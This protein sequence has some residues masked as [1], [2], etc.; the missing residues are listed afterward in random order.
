M[1]YKS[2]ERHLLVP[3]RGAVQATLRGWPGGGLRA[4]SLS[5]RRLS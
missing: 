5:A 1:I 3:A 2:E 4:E